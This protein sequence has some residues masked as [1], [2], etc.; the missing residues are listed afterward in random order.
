MPEI[1]KEARLRELFIKW[2]G[3]AVATAEEKYIAAAI[4]ISSYVDYS[5]LTTI[6]RELTTKS[7][8]YLGF[9]HRNFGALNYGTLSLLD[10][11]HTCDN[12]SSFVE[13]ERK[14]V[15]CLI[16]RLKAMYDD[17]KNDSSAKFTG[18]LNS[19][20]LWLNSTLLET[21]D[22]TLLKNILTSLYTM[23]RFFDIK[24]ATL[25]F[26]EKGILSLASINRDQSKREIEKLLKKIADTLEAINRIPE[27]KPQATEESTAAAPTT[28]EEYFNSQFL[29]IIKSSERSTHSEKLTAVSQLISDTENRLTKIIRAKE[30]IDA[31]QSQLEH[32]EQLL[33]A[34][35]QNEARV[36]G[37]KYA[38]QLIKDQRT[39][40]DNLLQNSDANTRSEWA[41]RLAKL[42]SPDL[43]RRTTNAAQYALSWATFLPTAAY[44]AWAPQ[45]LKKRFDSYFSLSTFDGECKIELRALVVKRLT[46]LRG[47]LSAA[48]ANKT[49]IASQISKAPQILSL[50]TNATTQKLKEIIA[51]HREIQQVVA[52]Y[53]ALCDSV[54]SNQKQLHSCRGLNEHLDL[55]INHHYSFLVRL[56]L[57]F[58]KF[59]SIF[60]TATAAKVQAVQKIKVE[61][62][63]L[64]TEYKDNIKEGLDS[65]RN[66]DWFTAEIRETLVS[67]LPPMPPISP[68]DATPQNIFTEFK[69]INTLFSQL[70]ATRSTGDADD[71]PP[72]PL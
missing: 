7:D 53:S 23:L 46:K 72:R 2:R 34:I 58:S 70:K 28:I 50:F 54:I 5:D 17:P 22:P 39:H 55:F 66:S 29:E 48:N 31:I 64:E 33:D 45:T 15:E 8:L 41:T 37:K 20:N 47:E 56:S 24:L 57:F 40:Y 67:Q 65:I 14:R 42:E 25:N 27:E 6:K 9:N 19:A 62:V 68:I 30:K 59:S 43:T 36:L 44:R 49:A 18:L 35:D 13:S 26:A 32:A 52:D 21:P 11:F 4:A 63:T 69:N 10:Y 3:S 71:T 60:T 1:N 38:S 51:S 16:E 61:L 12:N